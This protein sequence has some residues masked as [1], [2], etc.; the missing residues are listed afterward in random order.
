MNRIINWYEYSE[1]L[2]HKIKRE[3]EG[4]S[5]EYILNVNE[6]EYIRYL[7]EKYTIER[8]SINK[9]P[10][11]IH[12]PE[13]KKEIHRNDHFNRGINYYYECEVSYIFSGD[14]SL[15]EVQPS[16]FSIGGGVDFLKNND[17]TVSIKFSLYTEDAEEHKRLLERN[18]DSLLRR[19]DRINNDVI[20]FNTKLDSYIRQV[21]LS[22]KQKYKQENS[23]FQSIGVTDT[24]KNNTYSIPIIRKNKIDVKPQSK[25]KTIE[26]RSTLDD[27]TY[28]SIL[29]SIRNFGNSIEQKP[30]LYKGK[31]EEALRDLFIANLEQHFKFSTVTGETFNK[32]GKTDILIRDTEGN[33]VFIAECKVWKGKVSFNDTITQLLGYLTWKDCKTSIMFFVRNEGISSLVA[34][35]DDFTSEH[36]NYVKTIKSSNRSI[37]CVFSLPHDKEAKVLCEIIL[38]HFDEK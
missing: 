16:I 25:K 23:F 14:D 3:I 17:N 24:S 13:K 10:Q 33:N 12:P 28:N 38:F 35:L 26:S 36:I 20:S 37:R 11:T 34:K 22:L 30:S 1:N 32:K 29:E 8:L 4:N 7:T 31:D 6:E 21:F 5:K 27:D 2:S 19:V 15:W 9:E 18:Y